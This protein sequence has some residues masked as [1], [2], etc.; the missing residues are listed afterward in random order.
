MQPCRRPWNHC[1]VKTFA[2]G[3]ERVFSRPQLVVR[4]QHGSTHLACPCSRVGAAGADVVLR[5]EFAEGM[6]CR[7]VVARRHHCI[8]SCV[9]RLV[10]IGKEEGMVY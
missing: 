6:V 2:E 9:L 3:A 10:L 1:Y 4:T 8:A 5:K 7:W